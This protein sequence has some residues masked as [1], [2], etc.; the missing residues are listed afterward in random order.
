MLTGLLGPTYHSS[1]GLTRLLTKSLVADR[2]A[3]AAGRREDGAVDQ[4]EEER[5]RLV[6]RVYDP[7]ER[8]T[9][10]ILGKIRKET[11]CT[12]MMSQLFKPKKKYKGTVVG[13]DVAAF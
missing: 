11:L 1:L 4:L 13:F 8:R 3:G 2:G 12:S 5:K 10:S 7:Q 9:S 6:T